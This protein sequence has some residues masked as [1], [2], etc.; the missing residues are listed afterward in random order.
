MKLYFVKL[1]MSFAYLNVFFLFSIHVICTQ[2]R[3]AKIILPPPLQCVWRR[4]LFVILLY[5]L[6]ENCLS[7]LFKT[8]Q[9]L[10]THNRRA[11]S[12]FN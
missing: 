11:L 12:Y 3:Q 4:P 8:D 9:K 10:I 1:G 6:S 2:H 5:I 7:K